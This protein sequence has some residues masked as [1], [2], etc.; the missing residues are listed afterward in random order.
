MDDLTPEDLEDAL[1][2]KDFARFAN[3]SL[4]TAHRMIQDGEV[5]SIPITKGVRKIPRRCADEWFASITA[6]A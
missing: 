1:T 6:N 4:R 3:V 5:R 2:A